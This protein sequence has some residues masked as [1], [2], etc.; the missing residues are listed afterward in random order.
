[1]RDFIQAM[2]IVFIALI[3]VMSIG[4]AWAFIPHIMVCVF[5]G[6]VALCAVCFVY[7]CI[8]TYIKGDR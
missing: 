3:I 8:E 5:W 7:A 1:M 4:I 6:I 2:G